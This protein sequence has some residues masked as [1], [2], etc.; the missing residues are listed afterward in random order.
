MLTSSRFVEA[1][2]KTKNPQPAISQFRSVQ[3]REAKFG[4]PVLGIVFAD[5]QLVDAKFIMAVRY[6]RRRIKCK[7]VLGASSPAVLGSLQIVDWLFA[8]DVDRVV[9]SGHEPCVIQD[10]LDEV[11]ALAR[12]CAILISAADLLNRFAD[13]V[14]DVLAVV[15]GKHVSDSRRDFRLLYWPHQVLPRNG[16]GP[17]FA[18]VTS[19]LEREADWRS[20]FVT[21]EGLRRI[22]G[23]ATLRGGAVR[24]SGTP[25]ADRDRIWQLGGAISR[26]TM[27]A[28]SAN[29]FMVPGFVQGLNDSGVLFDIRPAFP[30]SSEGKNHVDVPRQVMTART[31]SD[32]KILSNG[33][34]SCESVVLTSNFEKAKYLGSML[35]SLA[36]QSS[37]N[38]SVEVWDDCSADGSVELL[39]AHARALN[40]SDG[41]LRI[42]SGAR[43]MGTY[44]IRNRL[45]SDHQK[46]GVR[47]FINDS[48][49]FS[50]AQRIFVQE[51]FCKFSPDALIQIC[52]AIRVDG[53]FRPMVVNSEIERYG[54]ATLS[55]S[56]LTVKNYGYFEVLKR[57]ADTEFIERIKR[58]GGKTGFRWDRIPVIFQPYDGLNLTADTVSIEDGSSKVKMTSPLRDLHRELF[59]AKHDGLLKKYLPGFYMFPLCNVGAEY[60][61]LGV[62]FLV[63][64][65]KSRHHLAVVLSCPDVDADAGLS[66]S[67]SGH[68]AIYDLGDS[69][70][71]IRFLEDS[72]VV[73]GTLHEAV[74]A[75][76]GWWNLELV[77][78]AS[79][80]WN[81][82]VEDGFHLGAFHVRRDLLEPLL[83]ASGDSNDLIS[84]FTSCTDEDIL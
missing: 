80:A 84:E 68:L 15:A 34:S 72:L 63:D 73:A 74:E 40:L 13:I 75:A 79:A 67:Q 29:E 27:N 50:S 46:D 25:L 61:K 81:S 19:W 77:V 76:R 53:D 2:L 14:R 35:Y 70:W 49:D 18:D 71:L 62:D 65:F 43:N 1:K 21:V 16:G 44:W 9:Y 69:S 66:L 24:Y 41:F 31:M 45:I 10:V 36:M 56:W 57:N 39:E 3:V 32:F 58:F 11:S 37:P 51:A 59:K 22:G 38:V 12:N 7:V 54:S 23:E 17:L 83:D 47:F 60:K 8:E 42:R 4:S 20:V 6:L 48:D 33:K 28:D 30:F 64:G 55:F 26:G 78:V 82:C 52:D 5:S